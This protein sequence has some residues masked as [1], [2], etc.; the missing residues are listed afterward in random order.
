MG[1]ATTPVTLTLSVFDAMM[2]EVYPDFRIESLA[3]RKRPLLE[4]IP[5]VDDWYGDALVVPVL[6]EDPQGYS[7]DLDKAITAAETT[8]Q[9]KFVST[10]RK[11]GYQV[12]NLGAEAVMAASKDVGAFV[13]AKE[14]QFSGALRNL[15]KQLHLQLYRSA[16]ALGQISTITADSPAAGKTLIVLTNKS[17]V[18][19]FGIG[20]TIMADDAATGDSPRGLPSAAKV[21]ARDVSAG[22]ITLDADVVNDAAPFNYAASPW[23]AND[24]LFVY[25]TSTYRLKGLEAWLPLSAPGGSDSFFGVNRSSGDVQGLSGHRVN[26]TGRSILEN[27]EELA[28]LIGEYGGEPDALFLNPRAG[29]QLAEDVGAKV[30]RNDGGHAKVGFS[31]FTLEHFVTGPVQVIFDTGCPVNRGFML[32]KET[33]KMHHMGPVPHLIR[34]DGRDGLR[35]ATTD[36]VQYRWR[37]FGDLMCEKPGWNGVMA[38][39]TA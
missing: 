10:D 24:Y 4:W 9:A 8:K 25:G 12:I 6:Y 23:A 30:T 28:M 20:Q 19:N 33:W 22:T 18:Y 1:S 16:A 35:G 17:D 11:H 31:G 21:E 15:G 32:Q 7:E 5:R 14:S 29:Q 2:K 26:N 38:V 39:A 37:W 13:R 3:I 27:A 34:D 36:T